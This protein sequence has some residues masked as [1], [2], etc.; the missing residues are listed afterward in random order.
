MYAIPCEAVGAMLD[1]QTFRISAALR[2]GL[3]L[4][5]AHTCRRCTALVT[6]TAEHGLHCRGNQGIRDR[7]DCLNHVISRTLKAISVSHVLEPKNLHDDNRLRPDGLTYINWSR[8]KCMIWDVTVTSSVSPTNRARSSVV[9]GKAAMIAEA[10]KLNRYQVFEGRYCIQPISFES[11]GCPGPLTEDFLRE[12]GIRLRECTGD[13]RSGQFFEERI[14]LEIQRGNAKA[15]L[16][17]MGTT[18]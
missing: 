1:N 12:V 6:P 2:L 9:T 15:I 10:F 7:H 4:G 17:S 11:H 13:P 3:P 8:G 14:S 18:E 5:E 16:S